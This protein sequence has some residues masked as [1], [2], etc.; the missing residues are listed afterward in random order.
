MS[1]LAD[2]IHTKTFGTTA[3][4]ESSEVALSSMV[5]LPT[6]LHCEKPLTRT[7]EKL[8]INKIVGGAEDRGSKFKKQFSLTFL[9]SIRTTD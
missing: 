1:K 2:W 3:P 7:G 5:L 6:D 8:E 4:V 9:G